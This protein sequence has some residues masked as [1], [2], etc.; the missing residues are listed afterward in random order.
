MK[1][2]KIATR[3][4]KLALAQAAQI[5]DK[6]R[7]IGYETELVIVKTAG[8][9]D[10]KSSL[11]T[12]GG[13]GLFVREIEKAL[14]DGRADLAVHSAKDLPFD[15]QEGMTVVCTP[16]AADYHDVLIMKK[17]VANEASGKNYTIGTSSPRRMLEYSVLNPK[18]EFLNLRGNITT[19][20]SKIGNGYDGI[21]LAKAGLDRIQA[22]LSAFDVIS[23]EPEQFIPACNQG[24]I[25][26]ECRMNDS[27]L[28]NELKRISDK[29]TYLR[30]KIERYMF[31]L[32]NVDCTKPAGVYA[33]IKEDGFRLYAMFE[34]RKMVEEGKL[35]EYKMVCERMNRNFCGNT[36]L[37]G[38]Q[39][40][41]K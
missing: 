41:Y 9:I 15:L 35:S 8:D 36:D 33:K 5:Q 30:F 10:R 32:M 25:A 27:V 29:D 13:N 16:K 14:V 28:L 18:A 4:S 24:I 39:M 2:L 19:R 40:R 34:G 17:N 38:T 3:G 23:Y 12:I 7:T 22:D 11:Q 1:I 31:R 6:L 26:V 20:L 37:V 21:I